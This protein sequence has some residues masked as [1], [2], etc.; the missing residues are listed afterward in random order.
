MTSSIPTDIRS[1]GK[2]TAYRTLVGGVRERQ[3]PLKEEQ[4]FVRGA[5][6]RKAL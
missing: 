3:G 1:Q 2:V 5:K 4:G 6:R